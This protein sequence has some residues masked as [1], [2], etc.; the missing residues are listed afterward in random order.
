[1]TQLFRGV[2]K[3]N[4]TLPALGV[5]ILYNYLISQVKPANE[6]YVVLDTFYS[7]VSVFFF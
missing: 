3:D 5:F 4:R 6:D 7:C 2:R 1:M